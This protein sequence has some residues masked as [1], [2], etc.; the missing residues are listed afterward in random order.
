MIHSIDNSGKLVLNGLWLS[1]EHGFVVILVSVNV[2]F[3]NQVNHFD[4]LS[5]HDLTHRFFVNQ[6][7]IP[8]FRGDGLEEKTKILVMEIYAFMW[9]EEER[10]NH[11]KW[12]MRLSFEHRN[13]GFKWFFKHQTND[14]VLQWYTP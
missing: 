11:P 6:K 10:L 4:D 8:L 1:G 7:N 13:D 12:E 14:Q 3:L 5:F 9:M 2:D